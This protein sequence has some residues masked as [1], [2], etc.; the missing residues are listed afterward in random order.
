VDENFNNNQDDEDFNEV[1]SEVVMSVGAG[2]FSQSFDYRI[3]SNMNK[4]RRRPKGRGLSDVLSY[5]LK[6]PPPNPNQDFWS[7]VKVCHVG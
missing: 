5:E 3:S 2:S 1:H 7:E 6:A 4:G